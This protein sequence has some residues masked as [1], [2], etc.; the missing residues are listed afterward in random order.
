MRHFL[1]LTQRKE[2]IDA[3]AQRMELVTKH[4]KVLQDEL[5]SQRA[6]LEDC[7]ERLDAL[8][9][10]VAAN[11]GAFSSDGILAEVAEIKPPCG[12]ALEPPVLWLLTLLK[13]IGG[14]GIGAEVSLLAVTV[15]AASWSDTDLAPSR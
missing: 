10:R 12:D 3:R 9:K 15:F 6:E 13:D 2:E 11:P 4:L 1:P 8:D 5:G 14:E 7:R